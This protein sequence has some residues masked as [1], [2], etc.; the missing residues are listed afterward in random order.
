MT[1][2]PIWSVTNGHV[3]RQSFLKKAWWQLSNIIKAQVRIWLHARD[4]SPVCLRP[5]LKNARHVIVMLVYNEARRMPFLLRYYRAMGFEH[6]VILDNKSTDGLQEQLAAEPDVS[7]FFTKGSFKNARYGMDWVNYVL[8]KYC[9]GKWILHVDADEFLVFPHCD[10]QSISDLTSYMET[11]HQPSLQ[12]LLLDMYSDRKISE[13]ICAIG[14]DPV[15]ICAFFDETGYV[16]YYDPL[17]E[18]LA[19]K[20]GVRG[21]VY[22]PDNL[23]K[24]PALNKTPLVR[25]QRHYAFLKSAHELWPASVNGGAPVPGVPH[26][27]LLHFK[28]LSDL[29][30]KLAAEAVRQQHTGEYDAYSQNG[31]LAEDGP[32]F[33]SPRS[34]KYEGWR[35]LQAAGLLDGADGL[36]P[37]TPPSPDDPEPGARSMATRLAP[38]QP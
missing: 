23:W 32:D 36:A 26:G 8:S 22:F 13:N 12:C 15:S 25:W 10:Q 35:S 6:F 20:G 7:L 29:T 4:V 2:A 31:R 18:T 34:R 17:N 3:G 28:F 1:H 5:G 33:M 30:E 21:R 19:I 9:A 14:E 24:G 16:T 37:Q 11:K 27:V 38:I